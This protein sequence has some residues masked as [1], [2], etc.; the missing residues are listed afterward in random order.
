VVLVV[1]FVDDVVFF[2]EEVSRVVLVVVFVDFVDD[3][4]LVHNVGAL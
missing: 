4:R 2:E 1:V 3:V